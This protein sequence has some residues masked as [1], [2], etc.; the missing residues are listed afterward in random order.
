MR[1]ARKDA[2]H[3]SQRARRGHA[4]TGKSDPVPLVVVLPSG[5]ACPMAVETEMRR[6]GISALLS[7]AGPVL[8]FEVDAAGVP[9]QGVPARRCHVR[10]IGCVRGKPADGRT[11]AMGGELSA[12]LVLR[13][14]TPS[15]LLSCV[16]AVT[17]AP[18]AIAPEALWE[19]LPAGREDM[20]DLRGRELTSREVTVLRMLAE[21]E[22]TRGIAQQLNYSERTVKNI[23]RNVLEKLGCRTRA[24]AVALA[25]R[26]GVI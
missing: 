9:E 6:N 5:E 26:N 16:R 21:G 10:L 11:Q 15:R 20:M 8:I 13:A 22:A 25:T 24:H 14:M 23:V 18:A 3:V 19:M 17:R 12:V 4:S 2:E 1:G 7:N